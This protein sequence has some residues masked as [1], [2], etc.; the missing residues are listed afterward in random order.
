MFENRIITGGD[1]QWIL[2]ST[3][4]KKYSIVYFNHE[5]T[6]T[7]ASTLNNSKFHMILSIALAIKGKIYEG[8]N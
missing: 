7:F 8:Y 2:D 3:D 1:I 4:A 5:A 6:F